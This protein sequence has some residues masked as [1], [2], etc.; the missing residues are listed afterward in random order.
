MR[1]MGRW[2]V[3][4][5][6]IAVALAAG[7]ARA[8]NNPNGTVFRAVG[9]FKGKAEITTQNIKCEIPTVSTAIAEGSFSVGMWNSYG[10]PTLFYPDPNGP[11]ANPCGGW[12]QVQNN[13]TDQAIQIDRIELRYKV[14]GARRFRGFVPTRNGFPIA[15]R[16]VRRDD[17]FVGAVVNPITSSQD[18]SIS[19]KPNVTFIEMLPLVSPQII[20][21][22][23]SQYAQLSADLFVSFPLV[24]RAT[25]VG[26]SDSG[27]TYRSNTISYHLTLRHTCGNGRVDDGELCDP[28]APDTCFGFC[29]LPQGAT[30][31]TCSQDDQRVCRNDGDCQGTCS[32]PN[33][34]TECVCLY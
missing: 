20:N 19:G 22:L 31:G 18:Q 34:P 11:F 29:V 12:I 14:Q 5:A 15:C 24:I 6:V 13:L 26:Q 30:N 9:W 27:D 32:P 10:F 33:N 4:V 23:R 1:I 28:M 21:C 2:E 8:D 16:E 3:G 25:A 7:A 17:H